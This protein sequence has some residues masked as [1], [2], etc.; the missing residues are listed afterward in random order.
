MD[1]IIP[2][3]YRRGSDNSNSTQAS[4][5]SS[6]STVPSSVPSL[7]HHDKYGDSPAESEVF[8]YFPAEYEESGARDSVN[9]YCST[10]P[11]FD[12]ILDDNYNPYFDPIYLQDSA[13]TEA[14]PATPA[15]FAELFP[16]IRRLSI[17]HDDSTLDGNMNVRVDINATKEGEKARNI[18]LFHLRMYDLRNRDFSLRRYGRDCGREVAH[19]KQKVNKAT[20]TRPTLQR[21]VSR[22]LQSFRGRSEAEQQL[23]FIR[24]DSG[25]SSG[26]DDDEEEVAPQKPESTSST[27]TCTLEFSNYAH[28]DLSRRG[29]KT[30]KKY[31]FEY[32]GKSY[33]WKR[34]IRKA[35]THGEETSFQ[36]VNNASNNIVAFIIPD[37]L[38]PAEAAAEEAKGGFIPPSSLWLRESVQDPIIGLADVADV[39]IATGLTAMV[40]D[41]IKRKFHK[42]KFVQLTLPMPMVK[43][44]LK[45]NMEY[46][47]PKRLIDEVFNRRPSLTRSPSSTCDTP[48]T[49]CA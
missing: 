4:D 39:I 31:D 19:I 21:S 13:Q 40:D 30:S 12:D 25:Y 44:P 7:E 18:T 43:S 45:M 48:K 28:V 20:P 16:T 22:A 27:N 47:G 36:L 6:R 9:T 24:R 5:R 29:G 10:V 34:V 14:V 41:C 42:K 33:S 2:R 32:W 26:L 15:E 3:F 49:A 23:K 35:G 46:V 38:S 37:P 17:K 1:S 11:A 8:E